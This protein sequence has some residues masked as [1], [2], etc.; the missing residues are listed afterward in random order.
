MLSKGFELNS[1]MAPFF[2]REYFLKNDFE[3]ANNLLFAASRKGLNL[4]LS[5]YRSLCIN[6]AKRGSYERHVHF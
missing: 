2:Y 1:R 5:Y 3:K 6:L 4:P